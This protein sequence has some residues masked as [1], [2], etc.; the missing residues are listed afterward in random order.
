ML[1]SWSFAQRLTALILIV[2]LA[3]LGGFG[4][5]TRAGLERA[6]IAAAEARVA[7]AA[8]QTSELFATSFRNQ[9][10][11]ADSVGR[12][13]RVRAY[14]TTRTAANR[15]QARQALAGLLGRV[16]QLGGVELWD[17]A[18]ARLIAVGEVIP[19]HD[20]LD[21]VGRARIGALLVGPLRR[22]ADSLHTA[23][24][25]PVRDGAR[26]LGF[27]VERR[28]ITS[29]P[30]GVRVLND[31]VGQSARLLI[32]SANGTWTD[33][34]RPV[35]APP[36]GE[37]VGATMRRYVGRNGEPMLGSLHAIAG[38][39]WE[40]FIEFPASALLGPLRATDRQ[41]AGFA[42]P[43]V[44][45]TLAVA[46]LLA[47]RFTA[48]VRELEAAAVSIADGQYGRR[49]GAE[50]GDE[51]GRLASAFNAMAARVE[52]SQRTL[53]QRV[54]DRTRELDLSEQRHRRN[55]DIVHEGVVTA[56]MDG[57]I[58]YAN[59]AATEM[60]GAG[61]AGLVGRPVA[62]LFPVRTAELEGV[63]TRVREGD[64]GNTLAAERHEWRATRNGA[65]E[66]PA[67]VAFGHTVVAGDSHLVLT[68]ADE[69]PREAVAAAK[70]REEAARAS[71]ARVRR[72]LDSNIIGIFFWDLQGRITGANDAFLQTIGYTRA[73][74]DA[75][76]VDWLALTPLEYAARDSH[77]IE[78]IRRTGTW[79]AYEKE[80]IRKDGTRVPVLLGG[81]AFEG[82]KS[83]G[84]CFAVDLTHRKEVEENLRRSN[85]ELERFAYV[86][87]HDLQE[88]LRMVHSYVQL[89]AERYRG[90]LDEDADEF[91]GF[92]VDGAARMQRLI[93]DLLTF[94]RVG[95]KG[96]EFASVD[97]GD[98]LR[99]TL[100]GLRLAIEETRAEVTAELLPTATVDRRQIAQVFQNLLGNALKF[101]DPA[102]DRPPRIRVSA[103]RDGAAWV[104]CVRDNGIGIDPQYYERIFVIFQRL[105]GRADYPGTGMGL[106]ICQKIVER[107]G[108]RIWVE[109]APGKGSAFFFTIP[110][111]R[112]EG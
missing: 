50:R 20:S 29:N 63:L 51:L 69:S 23:V 41:M 60:F 10:A 30:A 42:L 82:D 46:W 73:E 37:T 18:G 105:H 112:S 102:A 19:A 89:L 35:E 111:R 55:L 59:R 3:A 93:E 2:L 28:H 98:V 1:R 39:P 21:F 84:V 97:I 24:G 76:A 34:V 9:I 48:P 86:A 54:A 90:K 81:A 58:A 79:T 99:D 27:V 87:S 4:W 83:N 78:E 7:G 26:F 49:V 40:A 71:E 65:T 75:G 56:A 11:Q 12:D 72:L 13:P 62:S 47:H 103:Q 66:F 100:V 25:A 61:A 45:V 6:V 31:L 17:S 33:L 96:G 74:L 57:R 53:E 109:S 108:G 22:E 68:I 95:S 44:L 52:E 70:L 80:Y 8:R 88:P 104:F 38:S 64:P 101:R 16:S 32:G 5:L 36:A 110:D 15:E 106:A 43:I 67:S 77:A 14:L 85:V 92:A 94:S 91:I 107:H